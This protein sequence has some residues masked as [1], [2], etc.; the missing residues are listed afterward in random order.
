MNRFFGASTAC[1]AF[2]NN[3]SNEI[4]QQMAEQPD[5]K[6]FAASKYSLQSLEPPE[7]K[8]KPSPKH[9]KTPPK[10]PNPSQSPKAPEI[11]RFGSDIGLVVGLLKDVRTVG[12]R[13]P[14]LTW[15][16]RE[17]RHMASVCA[18]FCFRAFKRCLGGSEGA[19]KLGRISAPI[20]FAMQQ[21]PTSFWSA[22]FGAGC[23]GL[24]QQLQKKTKRSLA[25]TPG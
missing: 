20:I 10:P 9:P 24:S 3:V 6:T 5:S 12:M 14:A 11:G 16:P 19:L 15:R 17:I 22:N 7:P 21:D 8:Q 13:S 2:V 18:P 1:A 25:R 4:A 23:P